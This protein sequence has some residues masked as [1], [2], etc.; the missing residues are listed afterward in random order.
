ME[1]ESLILAFC[2]NFPQLKQGRSE[3]GS[4]KQSGSMSNA[5]IIIMHS[6]LTNVSSACS[7]LKI[8]LLLVAMLHLELEVHHELKEAVTFNC[9]HFLHCNSACITKDPLE[10]S[11]LVQFAWI[12]HATR[13]H[14][15]PGLYSKS[16]S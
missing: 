11:L 5:N 6:D 12:K 10:T 7:G 1:I 3:L 15:E 2:T 9:F 4:E 14:P 8:V 13:I 16:H